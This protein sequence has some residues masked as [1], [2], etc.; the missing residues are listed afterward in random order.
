MSLDLLV[1]LLLSKNNFI[2]EP[3]FSAKDLI[4]PKEGSEIPF[5]AKLRF[6][7]DVFLT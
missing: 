1:N 2:F 5:L 7:I 4:K 3:W 6:C